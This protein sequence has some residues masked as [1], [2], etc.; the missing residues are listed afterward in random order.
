MT[1]ILGHEQWNNIVLAYLVPPRE[2]RPFQSPRA[3]IF[4]KRDPNRD[5]ETGLPGKLEP[6]DEVMRR[7]LCNP[8]HLP[9]FVVQLNQAQ[10]YIYCEGSVFEAIDSRIQEV[11]DVKTG[12]SILLPGQA[13]VSNYSGE[14]IFRTEIDWLFAEETDQNVVD[15]VKKLAW[16]SGA[17][18]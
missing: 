15:R 8:D 2:D 5:D 14:T 7:E 10:Q 12:N 3:L 6:F 1:Q 9:G 4:T 18:L 13:A 11:D 17:K 16:T